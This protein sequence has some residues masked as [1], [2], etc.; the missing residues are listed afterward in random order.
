MEWIPWP[1]GESHDSPGLGT[2]A[3]EIWGRLSFYCCLYGSSKSEDS[4]KRKWFG[5]G[6]IYNLLGAV[7]EEEEQGDIQSLQPPRLVSAWAACPAGA[8]ASPT[9]PKFSFNDG[10]RGLEHPK[11]GPGML[12]EVK[13]K[14]ETSNFFLLPS[15]IYIAG[16]PVWQVWVP[17]PSTAFLLVEMDG[18]FP[19]KSAHVTVTCSGVTFASFRF[20]RC[21]PLHLILGYTVQK[22]PI[23]KLFIKGMDLLY[24]LRTQ[25][26]RKE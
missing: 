7:E 5:I 8:R 1:E 15:S 3:V 21:V 14:P 2:P 23:I 4:L 9:S 25:S 16:F 24:H 20:S 13:E 18:G 6:G 12:P 10:Q 19:V 11:V 22:Q 17:N 26:L